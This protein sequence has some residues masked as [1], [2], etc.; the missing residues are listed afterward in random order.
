MCGVVDLGP[1]T[2]E[3]SGWAHGSKVPMHEAKKQLKCHGYCSKTSTFFSR[4]MS[5]KNVSMLHQL[6]SIFV[7]SWSSTEMEEEPFTSQ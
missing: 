1:N 7:E 3:L 4:P 5:H 2:Q 6:L